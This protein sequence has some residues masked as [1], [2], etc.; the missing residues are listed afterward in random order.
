M[1]F[2]KRTNKNKNK[3]KKKKKYN[4]RLLQSRDPDPLSS[5]MSVGR[6][7]KIS[8]VAWLRLKKCNKL[9][10]KTYFGEIQMGSKFLPKRNQETCEK[11]KLKS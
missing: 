8:H 3:N 5:N 2:D 4:N 11:A 6:V 7:I 9:N 10:R 1:N